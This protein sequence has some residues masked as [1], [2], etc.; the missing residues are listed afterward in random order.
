MYKNNHEKRTVR[1]LFRLLIQITPAGLL[2]NDY[3]KHIAYCAFV[4]HDAPNYAIDTVGIY[5]ASGYPQS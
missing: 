4:Q 5:F 2:T 1:I 3:F